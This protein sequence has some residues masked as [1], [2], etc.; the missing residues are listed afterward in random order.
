MKHFGYALLGALVT[1]ACTTTTADA[2]ERVQTTR[3]VT[4]T[5]E[6]QTAP[7]ATQR[8]FRAAWPVTQRPVLRSVPLPAVAEIETRQPMYRI[9]EQQREPRI[10]SGLFRDRVVFPRRPAL[11]I[12]TQ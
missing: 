10:L 8:S 6:V 7:V 3:T 12:E 4:V 9:V 2:I 1:L 5:E 11:S